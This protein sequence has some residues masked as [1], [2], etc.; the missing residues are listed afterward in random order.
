MKCFKIRFV[1]FYITAITLTNCLAGQNPAIEKYSLILRDKDRNNRKVPVDIY[2]PAD[3]ASTASSVLSGTNQSYPLICFGHGYLIS[4]RWYE[5]IR[6]IVVPEGFIM[7]FPS[8]ETGLFPSHKKLAEDMN[9]VLKEIPVMADDSSFILHG[10]VDTAKCLMGHSMGGGS[11]FI[12][13]A[14]NNDNNAVIALAP[15]DTR[16][17]A[18]ESSAR[19]KAPTLIFAGSADCI[20][21]PEKHQIPIYNSSASPDKTLILIK[22]G[23]HCQM[24]VSHP[25]C[26]TGEKVSGC[27][28]QSLNKEEQLKIISR[29]LLPWMKFFLKDDISAGNAFSSAVTRDNEIE[30]RQ[31]RPL[32]VQ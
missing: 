27:K 3:T 25:K 17:S 32:P 7:I 5:D 30:L 10:L 2:F 29:Y 13:S 19:V 21:P 12:A 4:G 26:S 16:P 11:V 23:T 15:F 24:G 31:S 1:L 18:V 28:G 20:T 6:N 22:G 8:S 14:K 9:F